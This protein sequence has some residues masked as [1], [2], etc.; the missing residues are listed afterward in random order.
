MKQKKLNPHTELKA[1]TFIDK[2]KRLFLLGSKEGK[3]FKYQCNKVHSLK[4][5]QETIA[6]LDAHNIA[7]YLDF[8]TLIGAV[9]EKGFI[10]WDDDIDISLVHESDYYKIP[11][12]A[13]DIKRHKHISTSLVTFN[14]SLKNREIALQKDN[15]IKIHVKDID[16]TDPYNTRIL[17]VMYH[18]TLE[19]I[20]I[21]I[22]N[23]FGQ[24]RKGG[25]VLD[26]FIKYNKDKQLIWMAQNKIH[27]IADDILT[28]DL[29]DID[30]YTLKCKIPRDYDKY[31]TALYGKW[32]TPKK[33][34][35]YYEN[36]TVTRNT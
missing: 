8:G 1:C 28:D 12:L 18:S 6:S 21:D 25:Q 27:Q 26:I 36:N 32:K 4:L 33:D 10:E 24:N 13:Y 11:E 5:L 2:I 30:F 7:Y 3:K 34:W 16:F 29:V 9:R 17:K 19:K 31:L 23:I 22:L 15:T 35:Q 14:S 20:I